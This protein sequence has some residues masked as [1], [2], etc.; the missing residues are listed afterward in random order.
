M[1]LQTKKKTTPLLNNYIHH[2]GSKN[3]GVK[4]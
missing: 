4:I 1:Y 3:T 2:C